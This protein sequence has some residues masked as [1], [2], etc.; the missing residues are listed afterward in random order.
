MAGISFTRVSETSVQYSATGLV[1]DHAYSVQVYSSANA[2]W[3]D[4]ATFTAERTSQSGTI[5]VNDGSSY[6]ARIYDNTFG[7]TLASG[8]IPSYTVTNTVTVYAQ[9]TTGVSQFT[10]AYGTQTRIVSATEGTVAVSMTAG[11]AV[12][13]RSV[14]LQD[15][16]ES[17]YLL[18]YNTE[19]DP[20]GKHG[21]KEFTNTTSIDT[22]Y[23][24][25]IWV[26]ATEG[27]VYPYR[28]MIYVDGT[29][30]SDST[31]SSYTQ[32]SIQISAL[33]NF[34][35]YENQGYLF[36]NATANGGTYTSPASYVPL[37][38]GSTTTIRVY[39]TTP[40]R[41]VKPA[42]TNV[43]T[44]AQTATIT[45]SKNGGTQGTWQIYFGTNGA[46]MQLWGNVTTSP[47]TLTGLEAGVT[48]SFVVRNYVSAT[49]AKESDAYTAKT[50]GNIQ[51]FS[52]TGNDA[53]M[54][55][56]GMPV[57]NIT[58]S[59]W[60]ELAARVNAVRAAN[61]MTGATLPTAAAGQNMTAEGYNAMANAIGALSGAGSVSSAAKGDV[62]YATLFAND[63]AALKEAINR[64]IAKANA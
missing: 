57:S 54:I 16:Y 35:Y 49:D 36:Q 20:Y 59:A 56:K 6:S 17:P 7:S 15:G 64:A 11:T 60:A 45:W 30:Q 8:T 22:A 41:A 12:T 34:G 10:I 38:N 43:T 29:L 3:Y 21:P 53:G 19:S 9:C 25:R 47:V 62:I 14:Y 27:A 5:T 39:F 51:T 31:N 23:D 42:I 32:S 63:T 40:E 26:G 50:K 48:Y 28:Q 18:Y 1:L 24:R 55:A 2:K 46:G 33:S 37:T 13:I 52:W 61:G 44:T 58:A 4:K